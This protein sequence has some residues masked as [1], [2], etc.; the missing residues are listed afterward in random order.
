MNKKILVPLV[1]GIGKG[2]CMMQFALSV[3]SKPK[4]HS[5]RKKEGQYIVESVIDQE[6][7]FKLILA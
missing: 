3:A 7:D 4:F 2:K 6:E 1:E 5:N